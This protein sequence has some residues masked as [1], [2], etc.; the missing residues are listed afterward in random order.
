M[1]FRNRKHKIPEINS[2]SSADIAFLLLVFFL[3]T[4]SFD[5]KMGIYRKMSAP[6]AEN[7]L[8]KSMDV[9]QRNLLTLTIDA[10]NHIL[11]D[12]EEISVKEIRDLGKVF[13]THSDIPR[14]VISLEIDRK[15]S[16]QTYL[17]VVSELTAAYNELRSEAAIADFHTSWLRLTAGQKDSIQAAYPMRISEMEL[18][19]NGEGGKP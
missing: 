5:S 2:S 1:S 18:T 9:Q 4:S 13:I 19:V 15:A 12:E 14:H 17:S 6:V 3:V 16:Y 10:D 11:Y 7:V 8:K